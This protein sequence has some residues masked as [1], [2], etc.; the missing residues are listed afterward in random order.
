V[1]W[2]RAGGSL[3]DLPKEETPKKESEPA[4]PPTPEEKQKEPAASKPVARKKETK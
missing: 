3:E 2:L 1:E 4:L